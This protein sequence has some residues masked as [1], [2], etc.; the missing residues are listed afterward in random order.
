MYYSRVYEGE[1]DYD[2]GEG[3]RDRGKCDYGKGEGDYNATMRIKA[4]MC[5][6]FCSLNSFFSELL[7]SLGI[8]RRGM[9]H[10]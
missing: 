4:T 8:I 7:L 5:M 6:F 9:T 1:G 3:D 2:K 10:V